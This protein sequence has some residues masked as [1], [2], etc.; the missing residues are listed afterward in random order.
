MEDKIERNKKT[1]KKRKINGDWDGKLPTPK[2]IEKEILCE[3]VQRI[4]KYILYVW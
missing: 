3:T 1:E 2:E 4:Y